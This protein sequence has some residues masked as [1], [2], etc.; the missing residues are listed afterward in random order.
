LEELRKITKNLRIV[1]VPVKT[2]S[3]T[4]QNSSATASANLHD[5]REIVGERQAKGRKKRKE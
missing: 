3:S 5:K 2:N 1:S 4:K